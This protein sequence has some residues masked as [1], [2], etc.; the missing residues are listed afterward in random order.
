MSASCAWAF[1]RPDWLSRSSSVASAVASPEG[2]RLPH[3]PWSSTSA[4]PPTLVATMVRP[5]AMA[6]WRAHDVASERDGRTKQSNDRRMSAMSE[7]APGSQARSLNPSLCSR[8]AISLCN[9]P[10]PTMASRRRSVPG[11]PERTRWTKAST[12]SKGFLMSAWRPTVPMTQC[13]SRWNG[14]PTGKASSPVRGRNTRVS[15]PLGIRCTRSAAAPTCAH[16]RAWST[17]TATYWL[18]KG[19]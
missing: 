3:R 9:G 10:S 4:L 11:A 14:K 2:T 7:R 12:S 19:R 6:S 5:V 13:R 8:S 18:T 17:D 16:W 1:G 15:T